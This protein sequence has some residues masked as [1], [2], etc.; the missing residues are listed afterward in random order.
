MHPRV[1]HLKWIMLTL[2]FG[3]LFITVPYCLSSLAAIFYPFPWHYWASHCCLYNFYVSCT[4]PFVG[5]FYSKQKAILPFFT[6][7]VSLSIELGRQEM[8]SGVE[9]T[10]CKGAGHAFLS[11]VK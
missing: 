1:S 9:S 5:P 8:V 2:T 7:K 11:F 4:H 10:C 6:L 3:A